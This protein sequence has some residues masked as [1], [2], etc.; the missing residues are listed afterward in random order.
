MKAIKQEELKVAL[1]TIKN[2]AKQLD[3]LT[4][5]Q[6]GDHEMRVQLNTENG[7]AAFVEAVK[8]QPD[9]R[10]AKADCHFIAKRLYR[11][12]EQQCNALIAKI[13]KIV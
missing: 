11:D 9:L 12:D 8:A 1:E 10:V 7:W 3:T 4:A 2:Y 13:D 6:E 5:P